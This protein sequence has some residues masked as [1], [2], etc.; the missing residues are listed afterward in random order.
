MEAN[1]KV[2]VE[3]NKERMSIATAIE[4]KNSIGFKQELLN[5]L[6]TQYLNALREIEKAQYQVQ[7]RYD[8]TISKMMEGRDAKVNSNDFSVILTTLED[9]L[10][11]SLIDPIAIEQKIKDIESEIEGFLSNVDTALSIA[12]ATNFVEV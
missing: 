4:K 11:L 2:F 7:T 8:D 5:A 10:S 9:Q 12:N 1:A 3:I 6:R